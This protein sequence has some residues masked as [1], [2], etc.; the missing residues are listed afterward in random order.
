MFVCF[1]KYYYFLK[2]K[3]IA[4]KYIYNFKKSTQFCIFKVRI[5]KQYT[6]FYTFNKYIIIKDI[7]YL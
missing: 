3:H 6:Q 4:I 5:F 1:N 2:K 7:I